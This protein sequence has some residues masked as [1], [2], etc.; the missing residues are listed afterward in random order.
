MNV[1]VRSSASFGYAL[2]L[3]IGSAVSAQ[4]VRQQQDE[5]ATSSPTPRT[6]VPASRPGMTFEALRRLP[7]REIGSFRDEASALAARR[8]AKLPPRVYASAVI[9]LQ[10]VVIAPDGTI[11]DLPL[12]KARGMRA[13]RPVRPPQR[14]QAPD[15]ARPSSPDR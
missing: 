4:G 2:L 7:S 9:D 6:D 8:A 5:R 12:R 13:G 14:L 3:L 11:Y 1:R 10:Y 15:E